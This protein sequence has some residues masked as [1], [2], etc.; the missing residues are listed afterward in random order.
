MKIRNLDSTRRRR[1]FEVV[2]DA[3][4]RQA[5]PFAKSEPNPTAEDPGTIGHQLVLK[6]GV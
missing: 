1:R 5:F 6:L 2:T 3:G 4:H